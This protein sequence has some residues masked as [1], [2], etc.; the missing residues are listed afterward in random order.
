MLNCFNYFSETL[1]QKVLGEVDEL[2][3]KLI[4]MLK[5]ELLICS[6]NQFSNAI[7]N[8]TKSDGLRKR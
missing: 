7:M 5:L 4:L 3:K 6:I 1:P 8:K 2:F